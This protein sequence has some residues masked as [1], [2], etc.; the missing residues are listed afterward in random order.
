VKNNYNSNRESTSRQDPYYRSES[1]QEPYTTY[2]YEHKG[3][4]NDWSCCGNVGLH[5]F[6]LNSRKIYPGR[7]REWSGCLCLQASNG[8]TRV[9]KTSNRSATRQVVSGYNKVYTMEVWNE[10]MFSCSV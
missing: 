8:C 2:S 10:N 4:V 6:C 5:G 7:I 1:Y 9:D 3:Y